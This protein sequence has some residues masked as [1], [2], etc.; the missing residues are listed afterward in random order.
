V[1]PTSLIH[2]WVNEI[3]KFVPELRKLVYSGPNRGD[4]KDR[5][6]ETDLIITSYG[7]LRNDL[8]Q[9]EQVNFFMSYLTRA[10]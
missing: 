2:N 8:E 4:L 1:V 9:F 3:N 5:L 7:I 6:E 10:R